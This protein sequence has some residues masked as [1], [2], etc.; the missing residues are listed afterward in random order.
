ME[1]KNEK[2]DRVFQ[3]LATINKEAIKKFEE[4]LNREMTF[5][6]YLEKYLEDVSM[7]FLASY[8]AGYFEGQKASKRER[9]SVV[10]GKNK[11]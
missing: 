4:T 3:G 5:D 9:V 8:V 11:K 7:N 2:I 6:E 10:K 1:D